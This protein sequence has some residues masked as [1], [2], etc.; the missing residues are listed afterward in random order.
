MP[1]IVFLCNVLLVLSLQK[2]EK[3]IPPEQLAPKGEI[4]EKTRK[5][6]PTRKYKVMIILIFLRI[7][8]FLIKGCYRLWVLMCLYLYLSRR[9]KLMRK[10]IMG[11]Q[12]KNQAMDRIG[13]WA[14]QVNVGKQRKLRR[15]NFSRLVLPMW[16]SWERPLRRKLWLKWTERCVKKW[17]G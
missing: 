16:M 15:K 10:M 1:N 17:K 14:D 5:R 12:S 13:F 4:Y 3:K 2:I 8:N 7:C 9:Q 6:D 11:S